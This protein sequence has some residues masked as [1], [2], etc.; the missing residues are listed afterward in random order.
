MKGWSQ[1]YPV[2]DPSR[3]G[4]KMDWLL[5]PGMM[6]FYVIIIALTVAMI[7]N[8]KA[9]DKIQGRDPYLPPEL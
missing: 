3:A 7:L 4:G 5:T 8:G 6:V 2:T 1:S 9:I